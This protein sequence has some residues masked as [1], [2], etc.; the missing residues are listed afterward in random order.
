LR[1]P[2]SLQFHFW[3]SSAETRRNMTPL[4]VRSSYMRSRLLDLE[5]R[6][7]IED[8][9]SKYYLLI[10]RCCIDESIQGGGARNGGQSTTSAL[11]VRSKARHGELVHG[12]NFHEMLASGFRHWPCPDCQT[13]ARYSN[14]TP[15]WSGIRVATHG[16]KDARTQGRKDAMRKTTG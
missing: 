6:L 11:Y 5:R 16:R 3:Q 14:G 7:G 10:S 1:Q 13:K 15:S 8:T 4:V 12:K 2:Q 9:P